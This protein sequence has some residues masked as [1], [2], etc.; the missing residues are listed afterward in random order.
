MVTVDGYA[1]SSLTDVGSSL[2]GTSRQLSGSVS[3]VA[4]RFESG[5]VTGFGEL[6]GA[7]AFAGK[8]LQQ[9]AVKVDAGGG[10]FSGRVTSRF[11]HGSLVLGGGNESG[12]I[13]QWIAVGAGAAANADG[14]GARSTADARL[15]L[16]NRVPFGS[17]VSTVGLA[18]GGHSTYADGTV[19]G[20]WTPFDRIPA[21]DARLSIAVDAGVRAAQKQARSGRSSW[22]S[23]STVVRLTRS[24]FLVSRAGYEPDDPIRGTPGATS[25][26]ISIRA[27]SARASG[28]ES[29]ALLRTP[30]ATVVSEPLSE[31]RR[32]ITMLMP[33][34]TSVELM[35]D[36]TGWRPVP[37]SRD[38]DGH[39]RLTAVVDR[40]S[41][42]VNVRMDGAAWQVPPELPAQ[43]DDFG[44]RVGV[45]LVP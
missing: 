17:I 11:A 9:S 21:V 35:A 12:T 32:Q 15:G 2:W 41:H 33:G 25:F 19:H 39:W 37:M 26:A 22:L 40:G 23:G 5:S 28:D 24:L 18:S 31:G 7:F 10:S 4:A 29:L 34:A 36:F 44:G 6:H 13:S 1:R 42:R 20:E 8:G 14:S 27:L 30:K 45:L 16:S 3:A 38:S 43:D